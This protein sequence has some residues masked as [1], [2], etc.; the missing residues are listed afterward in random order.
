MTHYQDK[1]N[2]VRL[3]YVHYAHTDLST[4]RKFAQDF[5]FEETSVDA[6]QVFYRGYGNDPITYIASQ[7]PEGSGNQFKGVGFTARSREDFERACRFP[8]AKVRDASHRPG[9]GSLVVLSDPNGFPVEVVWDAKEQE[10]PR[11]TVSLAVDEPLL[12]NG[13]VDKHR[14]G[15]WEYIVMVLSS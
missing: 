8:G 11:A 13:A 7:A 10:L 14:K 12:T 6:D 9:G 3:S 4:F 15:M 2:I 1:I 5:G